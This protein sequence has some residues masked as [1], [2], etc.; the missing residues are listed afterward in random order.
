MF[1]FWCLPHLSSRAP[2]AQHARILLGARTL[3]E[4]QGAHTPR[5]PRTG[6]ARSARTPRRRE[7]S[8]AHR[9][10]IAQALCAAQ[11]SSSATAL[12]EGGS[13]V[14][15]PAEGRAQPRLQFPL[16]AR[17]IPGGNGAPVSEK[18]AYQNHRRAQALL[19]A[20]RP[21]V[22]VLDHG[23]ARPQR[24]L[25]ILHRPY[26]APVLYLPFPRAPPWAGELEPFRLKSPLFQ[27]SPLFGCDRC[28]ASRRGCRERRCASPFSGCDRCQASATSAGSARVTF[29]LA[30]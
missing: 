8:D 20:A 22:A 9:A 27:L 2:K 23:Q 6:G 16:P 29:R 28:Q 4:D 18:P 1:V 14:L 26:R 17:P 11:A 21:S 24:A 12:H 5:L 19:L 3:H 25:Q 15:R 7:S 30:C 13:E 10:L